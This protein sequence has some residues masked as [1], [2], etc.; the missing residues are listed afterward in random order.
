MITSPNYLSYVYYSIQMWIFISLVRIQVWKTCYNDMCVYE[1]EI[2]YFLYLDKYFD[3]Q[4]SKQI[5]TMEKKVSPDEPPTHFQQ[6][7]N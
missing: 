3:Y 6:N 1:K 5:N 2:Y 4:L 7:K